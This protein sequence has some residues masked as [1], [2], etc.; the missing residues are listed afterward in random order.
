MF[1]RENVRQRGELMD[2]MK[3]VLPALLTPLDKNG[4]VKTELASTMISFYKKQEA[5]GL[6]ML[7]WT[8]EGAHLEKEKR[9]Q[10]TEAVLE[11]S[12]GLLPVF[13]HVGYNQNLDDSIELAAHAAAHGAYAVSSVGISR[14]ASFQDNIDYFCRISEAAPDTP[15]FIYWVDSGR[16]LTGDKAISPLEFLEAM[17]AVPTFQGIK[18]TDTNFY[19]LERFKKHAPELNILTGADELAYCS[20]QMGADGNIGALQA[21]TC[22]HYKEMMRCLERGEY[23][24]AR[25]LQYQANEVSETYGNSRIGSL[26]GIKLLMKEIYGIDVGYCSPAGPFAGHEIEKK[27]AEYL[28]EVFRKNIRMKE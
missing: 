8:G 18:F 24:E 22:Y 14:E 26:P 17:K 9:M 2:L 13:V 27:D 4:N 6:Y 5:D 3:G 10:W 19:I 21:V 11:A 25:K 1:G 23:A 7:G 12:E 28:V 15:F 16:T 20:K